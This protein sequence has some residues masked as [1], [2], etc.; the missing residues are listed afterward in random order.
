MAFPETMVARTGEVGGVGGWS[1]EEDGQEKK[2]HS[3]C[4]V[5][6][7]SGVVVETLIVKSLDFVG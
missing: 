5:P 1:G 6:L 4:C 3:V 7:L 2:R